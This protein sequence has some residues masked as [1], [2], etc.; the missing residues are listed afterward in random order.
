MNSKFNYASKAKNFYSFS[1]IFKFIAIIESYMLLHFA[2]LTLHYANIKHDRMHFGMVTQP[3][4]K[5]IVK[6]I[7][8]L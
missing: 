6:R 8:T 3:Q 1:Q 4:V 7:F 2:D 5:L